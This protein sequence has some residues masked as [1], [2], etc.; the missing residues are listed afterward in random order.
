MLREKINTVSNL[1]NSLYS[2]TN[3]WSKGAYMQERSEHQLQRTYK[4][5][6]R[7]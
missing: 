6:I 4:L 7:I 1:E 2:K 3:F 5:V